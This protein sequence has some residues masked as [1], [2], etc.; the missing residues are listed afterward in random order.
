M[1]FI[2]KKGFVLAKFFL[3]F[4]LITSCL[5]SN[6]D[7]FDFDDITSLYSEVITSSMHSQ[8]FLDSPSVISIIERDELDEFKSLPE[9][10]RYLT[11]CEYF[12]YSNYSENISLYGFAEDLN[13]NILILIDGDPIFQD[14]AGDL[15]FNMLPINYEDIERVEILKSAGSA[16]YGSNAALGAINLITKKHYSS[17]AS[18]SIG[19]MHGNSKV[20]DN[21]FYASDSIQRTDYSLDYSISS[22][23]S[24]SSTDYGVFA[25]KRGF[26]KSA[27]KYYPPVNDSKR[28]KKAS[29]K[30]SKRLASG[31][32]FSS[33]VSF[34]KNSTYFPGL[35]TDDNAYSGFTSKNSF[36]A[37]LSYKKDYGLGQNRDLQLTFS[38]RNQNSTPLLDSNEVVVTDTKNTDPISYN[39][40]LIRFHRS[41]L[42]SDNNIFNPLLTYGFDS[43]LINVDGFVY[44]NETHNLN[45]NALFSQIELHKDRFIMNLSGRYDYH[46]YFSNRAS[47][48]YS[49]SYRCNKK[50]SIRASYT[51]SFKFP[52][53]YKAFADYKFKSFTDGRNAYF[54]ENKELKPIESV[55]REITYSYLDKKNRGSV[56]LFQRNIFG[57]TDTDDLTSSEAKLYGFSP[58]ID[59]MN[60]IWAN[61]LVI[62]NRGIDLEFKHRFNKRLS[63]TLNFIKQRTMRQRNYRYPNTMNIEFG[64]N[65]FRDS[66]FYIP[67]YRINLGFDYSINKWDSS[68][69]YQQASSCKYYLQGHVTQRDPYNVM[70]F[71]ISYK[72]DPTS[73]ISLFVD[74]LTD[75][76]YRL[77]PTQAMERRAYYIEIKHYF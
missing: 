66:M 43:E 17:L 57:R 62:K 22:I 30:Y 8:S 16:M 28:L 61:N 2:L 32:D 4:L 25:W 40:A 60:W 46:S 71:H 67:H 1:F 41:T 76:Q 51:R 27:G 70:H 11:N 26:F 10:L 64:T 42:L 20:T 49:L 45:S 72:F 52:N 37:T 24:D 63:S 56:T 54:R 21:S 18:Y 5:T 36:L 6:A 47:S 35:V 53:L 12:K 14:M 19:M 13:D 58:T 73:T 29:F 3:L 65:T 31:D 7:I 77:N 74:N 50:E 59:S 75:E 34:T 44:G 39:S 23:L 33:L 48:R 55:Y 68:L 69:Y 15:D 38:H 9:A